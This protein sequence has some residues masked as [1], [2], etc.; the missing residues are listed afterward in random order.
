MP[1]ENELIWERVSSEAGPDLGLLRVRYDWMRHPSGSRTLKRLVLESVDWVNC[2]AL[3]SSG[4]AV[5]VEQFR[6]G[7][8]ACTLET[9]GGMVDVG[10]TPLE[11]AQRELLEETGYGGGSW[12][13]LGAVEPNP[14]IHGH[15]CHHFLATGVERVSAPN[16]G[17]G[18]A[19]AA[20]LTTLDGVREAMADG[21][22]RHVLALSALSRVYDLFDRPKGGKAGR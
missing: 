17:A 5:M 3:T 11:A 20:R 21:R 16:P 9:P 14:A 18:E 19:I 12:Q 4:L 7:I 10:E 22:L 1:D 8:G 2:V 13:S 15:L 6:F